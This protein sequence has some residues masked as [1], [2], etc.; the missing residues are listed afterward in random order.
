MRT[1]LSAGGAYLVWTVLWL[2]L[3]VVLRI[4]FG[5]KPEARLH[6]WT[7]Y[8]IILVAASG[9]MSVASGYLACRLGRDRGIQPAILLGIALLGTGAVVQWNYRE[10]MPPWYHLI[11][12]VQL[13]PDALAG[14]I[15]HRARQRAG[16]RATAG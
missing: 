13:L 8:L 4:A 6:D 7:G 3:N 14:G 2:I 16:G 12:L 15:L 5:I 1:L 10:A 9:L 11:F